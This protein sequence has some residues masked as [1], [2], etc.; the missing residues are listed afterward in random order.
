MRKCVALA[1]IALFTTPVFANG[2]AARST[3]EI[4]APELGRQGPLAIGTSYQDIRLGDREVLTPSGPVRGERK[5]G[6]R[7][8]YPAMEASG[9]VAVYRHAMTMPDKS[10]HVVVEHGVAFEKAVPKAGKFPVVVIS[11]GFGGW[12]EH[13]SRL[14]E[15]LAS[16]GYVV[17]AIDHRD[18]HFTD[19][20]GFLLSFGKVLG[21]RSL[22]Q[23]QIIRQL[24]DPAFVKMHSGLTS[25][26]I[27]KVGIIGYSMGGFGALGTAGATYDLAGKPFAGLPGTFKTQATSID[28]KA[29]ALVDATVL[30]APWGG[31]PDNR[32]WTSE[33]MAKLAVPA[34]FIA[35]DHDDVVNYKGGVRWLFDSATASD[36]YLLS[37]REAG[38]NLAGNASDLGPSPSAEA[39]GY[40]REPVW[41]QERLN[42][43]NQ[44]FITAFLDVT[45][46][47]DSA[48]RRYL[49]V[50]TPVASDGKWD[51]AFGT[52]DGDALAGDAQPE[53]WRGF[54]RRRAIGME[55]QH[56]AR[57][58]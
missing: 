28:T 46:K 12:S 54:Q 17:L 32:A 42:Q 14:G 50:P 44:H 15:H 7:I 38:H 57:G 16:H 39:V 30:M 48:K 13:L 37:F 47:N 2:N 3:Y 40:A 26:D 35:G 18:M 41:R 5:L 6:L 25:A 19:V 11:H 24:E 55:M 4:E 58:Q 45:L 43:I 10:K 49:D 31:Q 33:G 9:T 53:Y 34:L 23:Q 52:L 22:D 20:P 51:V 1:L 21:D 8:W 27:D 56:K 29:T 36:R